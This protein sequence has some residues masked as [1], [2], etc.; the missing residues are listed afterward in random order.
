MKEPWEER[1][2][3]RAAMEQLKS[4]L[5]QLTREV[6]IM[7]EALQFAVDPIEEHIQWHRNW[8]PDTRSNRIEEMSM[9]LGRIHAALAM[10]KEK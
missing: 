5:A 7:R 9:G 8:W 6:E 1:A 2:D 10:G 4:Q 3:M